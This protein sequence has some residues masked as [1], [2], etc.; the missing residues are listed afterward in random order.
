MSAYIADKF[1]LVQNVLVSDKRRNVNIP[2]EY[3]KV[4]ATILGHR[5]LP[6]SCRAGLGVPRLPGQRR[7]ACGPV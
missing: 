2:T 4:N 7:S 3:S 1:V 6:P 5:V